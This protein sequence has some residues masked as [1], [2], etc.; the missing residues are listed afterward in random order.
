MAC[1]LS[2]NAMLVQ[3]GHQ[4]HL[5]PQ[6]GYSVVRPRRQLRVGSH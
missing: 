4:Q 3:Q 6:M 5:T 2:Q 1:D